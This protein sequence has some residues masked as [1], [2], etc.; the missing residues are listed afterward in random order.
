MI[1]DFYTK[2]LQ[3]KS[4]YKMR[5]VIMGHS[6]MPIEERVGEHYKKLLSTVLSPPYVKK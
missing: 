4:Y 5:Q 6:N 1:A 3:D 2:P